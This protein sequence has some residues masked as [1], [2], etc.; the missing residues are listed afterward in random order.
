MAEQQRLCPYSANTPATCLHVGLPSVESCRTYIH[1]THSMTAGG[2]CA[3][4]RQG[5]APSVA[6]ITAPALQY[7]PCSPPMYASPMPALGGSPGSEASKTHMRYCSSEQIHRKT[8][9]RRRRRTG[10]CQSTHIRELHDG[11][12][13]YKKSRTGRHSVEITRSCEPG[14][15]SL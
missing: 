6:S 13:C 4:I 1:S 7:V 14:V 3:G 5:D 15:Q 12:V 9:S 8:L 2:T 10:H 11:W